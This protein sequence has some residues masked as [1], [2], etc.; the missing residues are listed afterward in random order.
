[1]HPFIVGEVALGSVRDRQATL[2]LLASLPRLQP[3]D[4]VEALHLVERHR[5]FSRGI[6]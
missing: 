1:M 2:R 3:A 5:L 4:D 6:G